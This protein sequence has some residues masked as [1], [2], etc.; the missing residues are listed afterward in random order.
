MGL[1]TRICAMESDK[2]T[3]SAGAV[4]LGKKVAALSQ[5]IYIC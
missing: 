2:S 1:L 5:I 4:M 3:A